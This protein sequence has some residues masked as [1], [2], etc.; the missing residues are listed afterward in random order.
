[1]SDPTINDKSHFKISLPMLFQGLALIGVLVFGYRDL[2]GR[3]RLL[4]HEVEA[5]IDSVID[6]EK[7]KDD[8]I[9]SDVRQDKTLEFLQAQVNGNSSDLEY[10]KRKIYSND[11]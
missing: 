11:R 6:L 5:T 4:E 8:P 3:I 2:E 7:S 10:L 1:M 9:P